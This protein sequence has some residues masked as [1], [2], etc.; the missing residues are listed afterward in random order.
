MSADV[1]KSRKSSKSGTK[2]KSTKKIDIPNDT[3]EKQK[4][5][6]GNKEIYVRIVHFVT[7]ISPPMIAFSDEKGAYSQGVINM[8][9]RAYEQYKDM[10]N[11]KERFNNLVNKWQE[12]FL[13]GVNLN[14]SD[15]FI[16][17]WEHIY[18]Y[19]HKVKAKNEKTG[20]MEEQIVETPSKLDS[21]YNFLSEDTISEVLNDLKSVEEYAYIL[22]DKDVIDLAE[23]KEQGA[24]PPNYADYAPRVS[25]NKIVK[26]PHWHI[27]IKF[28]RSFPLSCLV[29]RFGFEGREQFFKKVG[30]KNNLISD[31]W[32]DT[33]EYLT[34]E[35]PKEQDLGKF[36]Y[37]DSLVV[38][39]FDWRNF[40]DVHVKA[41]SISEYKDIIKRQ[42]STNGLSLYRAA[43][44][45][46][47]TKPYDEVQKELPSLR[48]NY[49][50]NI[51]YKPPHLINIYIFGMGGTGKDIISD[52]LAFFLHYGSDALEFETL[53]GD[54]NMQEYSFPLTDVG[55]GLSGYDGQ[56]SI[57]FSDKRAVDLLNI[58]DGRGGTFAQFDPYTKDTFRNV[59][60]SSVRTICKYQIVND[61]EEEKGNPY[62]YRTFLDN[63]AGEYTDKRTGT[64]IQSE[65]KSQSYRR[66][67]IIIRCTEDG[68]TLFLNNYWLSNA[69][70]RDFFN[71]KETH[72]NGVANRILKC[73]KSPKEINN[74]MYKF[75]KPII[76]AVHY[77]EDNFF[78]KSIDY[79]T[80]FVGMS[81]FEI[82]DYKIE[83]EISFVDE[84]K[85][86]IVRYSD[87]IKNRMKKINS[88]S[89]EISKEI[90]NIQENISNN[91]KFLSSCKNDSDVDY[92][93]SLIKDLNIRETNL[94]IERDSII[95]KKL[96]LDVKM[97]TVNSFIAEKI[98]VIGND[99]KFKK[100]AEQFTD[101]RNKLFH[102]V[103]KNKESLEKESY[104]NRFLPAMIYIR[105][106]PNIV[107]AR[108]FDRK[109]NY[110]VVDVISLMSFRL[111]INSKDVLE[112]YCIDYEKKK[113]DIKKS[114]NFDIYEGYYQIAH[115]IFIFLDN[116]YKYN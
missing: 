40:I 102:L 109:L 101:E 27:A 60:Y 77:F 63:L 92:Y 1:K 107:P 84:P 66:F 91:E 10:E 49:L 69:T 3:E 110:P 13:G 106:V 9:K 36:R 8:F 67:P 32:F 85:Q 116:L 47:G 7:Q 41:D 21:N 15:Y 72:Y 104:F 103:M 81:E 34:H 79:D 111:S 4:D 38:A 26:S 82:L 83:N 17:W 99:E 58:F 113:I 57:I 6:T 43:Q 76:D 62:H 59:K 71:Y 56:T 93:I 22:H 50:R 18:Y 89:D 31:A 114:E 54:Y 74:L 35:S 68:Y 88:R 97:S 108:H 23:L 73:G 75:L 61:I 16:D 45:Y 44:M 95:E 105:N 33:V 11:G 80:T 65:D 39:N 53:K 87:D 25:A 28:K 115:K 5:L 12:Q 20:E 100:F 30:S 2:K 14:D 78:N 94:K 24:E 46:K 96:K 42:V 64:N 48:Y 37:D 70:K 98:Y 90:R 112:S 86:K 55:L 51:A 29:K 52:W 19:R